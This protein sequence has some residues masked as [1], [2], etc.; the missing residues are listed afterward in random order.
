MDSFSKTPFFDNIPPRYSK[1]A[2]FSL[3]KVKI[4]TI[5]ANPAAKMKKNKIIFLPMTSAKGA[6][7]RDPK[8]WNIN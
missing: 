8:T 7:K 6:A 3:S 2:L 4:L 5:F 1:R